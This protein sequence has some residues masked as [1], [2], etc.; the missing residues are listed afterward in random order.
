MLVI[1]LAAREKRYNERKVIKKEVMPKHF[2]Q[3]YL[4]YDRKYPTERGKKWWLVHQINDAALP[5]PVSANV[6]PGA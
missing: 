2:Q 1:Q 5:G 4:R 3:G 6:L